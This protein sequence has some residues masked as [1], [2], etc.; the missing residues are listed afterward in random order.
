MEVQAPNNLG[1]PLLLSKAINGELDGKWFS[2]HCNRYQISCQRQRIGLLHHTLAQNM[3][4]VRI[5]FFTL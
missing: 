2:G 3:F 5:C 1:R 4:F